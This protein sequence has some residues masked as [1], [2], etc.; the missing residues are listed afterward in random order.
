MATGFDLFRIF[1]YLF[2]AMFV[3]VFGIIF[4][5]GIRALLGS[6]HDRRQPQVPVPARVVGRR[7]QVWGGGHNA[8]AST[9]QYVTF[10]FTNTQ[11]LELSVPASEAG[12][13]VEGDTGV[14]TFQGGRF[15]SFVRGASETNLVG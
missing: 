12:Y 7:T 11:R 8:P 13:L 14:L 2:V 5:I 9:R 1:P 15:I 10:E 3:L 6:A 4:Y